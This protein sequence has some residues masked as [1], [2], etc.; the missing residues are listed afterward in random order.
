MEK[1]KTEKQFVT[2]SGLPVK[3]IYTQGDVA[4]LNADRDFGV[5]GTFPFLRGGYPGMYR[6]QPW[7]IRQLTAY[8]S[9]E[10][11][12]DRV[13]Y[14]ISHGDLAITM[15]G[16]FATSSMYDL[17]DQPIAARTCDVGLVGAPILSLED[18]E[19]ILEGIPLDKAYIGALAPSQGQ[20]FYF[21]CYFAL[22][23]KQGIPL[24]KIMGT[25]FQDMC[26]CYL[27][28]PFT[29]S[30]APASALKL[31]GDT[32]EY[33]VENTPHVTTGSFSGYN[34]RECGI[35]AYQEIAVMLACAC[36]YIDEVLSRGKLKID[37][38]AY[39]IAGGHMSCDRDFFEE[40]AKF[41][42]MRRC[43]AKLMKNRYGAQN[44]KSMMFRIHVQTSGASLTLHQPMNNVVRVA[45][46]VLAAALGGVQSMNSDCYDEAVSVPSEE[47]ALLAIRT[48]QIAQHELGIMN[49]AD[50]LGGSYYLERLS[51]DLEEKVWDY[52]KKI[53]EQGGFLAALESGWLPREFTMGMLNEEKKAKT[54]EKKIVGVNCFTMDYEP[55]KIKAF[56]TGS[57]VWEK[58]MARLERLRQRRDKKAVEKALSDLRRAVETGQNVMP[59]S[60]AAGRAYVTTGEIGRLWREIYPV[61]K[62]PIASFW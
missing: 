28:S 34:I 54:G 40:I 22:A 13:R 20:P 6:S 7:R 38:F 47:A 56:D 59:A 26:T 33:C 12:R 24:N 35:T 8:G 19:I 41:R 37:D 23:E 9:V 57:G 36:T 16:D 27:A 4:D 1:K 46:Q 42:I 18:W 31:I 55:F 52:L 49:V 11:Q 58:E 61:I 30:I 14:A 45:Y 15:T 29:D 51:N 17:D 43:W 25:G 3:G 21:G 10:D 53:D 5:P 60:I 62:E 44:P 48:Q 2:G 50:P 39:S 32:I